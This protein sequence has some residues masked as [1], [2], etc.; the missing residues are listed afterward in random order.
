M[1]SN[2]GSA[3]VT[4]PLHVNNRNDVNYTNWTLKLD[5]MEGLLMEASRDSSEVGL[6]GSQMGHLASCVS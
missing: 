5:N 2:D 6:G 3:I 4:S 1:R